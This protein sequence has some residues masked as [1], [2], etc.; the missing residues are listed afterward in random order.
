MSDLVDLYNKTQKQR[1]R[2]ARES[3]PGAATDYFDREH[4]IADGF[5]TGKEKGDPTEFKAEAQNEY[6]NEVNE[7]T[8][9][10]SYN[11]EFPLHRWT[12]VNKY[13]PE[14]RG[15]PSIR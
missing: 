3:I 12:N 14:G 1:P 5:T 15:D 8:P 10:E 2:E 13:D 4:K 6:E 9:P 11:P 7:L